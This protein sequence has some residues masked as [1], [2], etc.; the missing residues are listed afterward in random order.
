M[1]KMTIKQVTAYKVDL[2]RMDRNGA[3]RCPECGA[4]ITPDDCSDKVYSILDINVK[5]YVLDEVVI[6]CNKCRSHIHLLGF[7]P[8]QHLL[9][10][11][12]KDNSK[13][14]FN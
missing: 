8:L 11:T 14:G 2:S 1:K 7:Q 6:R 4:R 5:N 13:S 3:F 9:D 12:Q 10:I